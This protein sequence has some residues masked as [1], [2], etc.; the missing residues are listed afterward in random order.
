LAKLDESSTKVTTP[1]PIID[2]LGISETLDKI[3]EDLGT[4]ATSVK[5]RGGFIA[6][7]KKT[8]DANKEE[9]GKVATSVKDM[10]IYIRIYVFPGGKI[11]CILVR[12]WSF[13]V[14]METKSASKQAKGH[15][16]GR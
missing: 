4:V 14:F 5:D 6:E 10:G 2:L 13:T 7:T 8:S 1:Q 16:P 12:S 9:L 3:K 15:W 11:Y